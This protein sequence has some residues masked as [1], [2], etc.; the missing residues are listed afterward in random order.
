VKNRAFVSFLLIVLCSLTLSGCYTFKS[1]NNSEYED[2]KITQI[3][4]ASK[5]TLNFSKHESQIVEIMADSIIY[6]SANSKRN[7]L[8]RNEIEQIN[9][10]EYQASKTTGAIIGGA[11]GWLILLILVLSY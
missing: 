10:K 9:V 5:D 8:H 6:N 7:S 1:I 11:F 3:I 2:Q 4:T